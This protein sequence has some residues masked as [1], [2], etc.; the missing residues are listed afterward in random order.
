MFVPL[1]YHIGWWFGYGISGVDVPPAIGTYWG[2]GGGLERMATPDFRGNIVGTLGDTSDYE[3]QYLL[4]RVWEFIKEHTSTTAADIDDPLIYTQNGTASKPFM[5]DVASALADMGNTNKSRGIWMSQVMSQ[6]QKRQFKIDRDAL[7]EKLAAA[8][9]RPHQV[10][11][12]LQQLSKN[13]FNNEVSSFNDGFDGPFDE[14]DSFDQISDPI[15]RALF[16]LTENKQ[17]RVKRSLSS[18]WAWN[19]GKTMT[20]F[21]VYLTFFVCGIYLLL[22]LWYDPYS[23]FFGTMGWV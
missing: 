3:Q 5:S 7:A 15:L 9:F 23:L 16:R 4:I 11:F 10:R 8:K 18:N 1:I 14:F 22:E 17:F 2:F 20:L 12:V 13:D 19:T 21:T 6:A